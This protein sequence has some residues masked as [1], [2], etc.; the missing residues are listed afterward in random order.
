M[1][2]LLTFLF[3]ICAIQYTT[4]QSCA[5][6]SYEFADMVAIFTANNCTTCHGV[7]GGLNLSDYNNVTT[8]G[9]SGAGGCGPYADPISF[10]IGKADGTLTA[11]DGCGGAMPNGAAYGTVTFSAADVAAI[12]AW[13]TAGAPEFCPVPP[14]NDLCADATVLACGGVLTGEDSSTSTD[15]SADAGCSMG[16]GVWYTIVGTGDN[17]TID[18]TNDAFDVEVA[19]ASGACGALTNI[20]CTDGGTTS[21]ST[22]FP[23]VAGTT[24]YIYVGDYLTGGTDAGTF[25]LAV[26]C[27]PPPPPPAN[28]MCADAIAI[29]VNAD[30]ACGMATN[31]TIEGATDSGLDVPPEDNTICGGTEDDDVWF[32]F[33]ATGTAHQIDLTNITGSTTDL[34]HSVWAGSCGTLTNIVCSDPNTSVL[35]GLTPGTTYYVRVY[36]WT[37]TTGQDSVFDICVGTPPPPPA[38]DECVDAIALTA[39]TGTC[40]GTTPGTTTSSTESLPGCIGTANDDV[41]FSFV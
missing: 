21:E 38:N 9:N 24:Y 15:Q 19:I 26:T 27:V 20:S 29:P 14:A 31:A 39:E 1:K 4:A 13:Q 12:Q 8:G 10:L 18:I 11:A 23:T 37:A 33:V 6:G 34:Y 22:T 40:T 30:L 25:D 17:V 16:T 7:Q 28:D 32:S 2:K 35:T 3:V 36:S 41:W 5:D